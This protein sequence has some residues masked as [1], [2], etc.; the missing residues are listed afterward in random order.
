[1]YENIP[2]LCLNI[3]T[4]II[5]NLKYAFLRLHNSKK[6]NFTLKAKNIFTNNFKSK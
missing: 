3:K 4:F 5:S 6:N 2:K 1:M